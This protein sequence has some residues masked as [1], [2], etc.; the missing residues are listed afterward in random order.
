MTCYMLCG[1]NL[2]SLENFLSSIDKIFVCNSSIVLLGDFNLLDIRWSPD[3]LTSLE[4]HGTYSTAFTES[5][6]QH[7]L[8]QYVHSPTRCNNI[9]DLVFSDDPYSICNLDTCIPF[10]TSDH[11][12]V[13]FQLICGTKCLLP[14]LTTET[15]DTF[16]GK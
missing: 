4:C 16:L 1:M 11:N 6:I 7:G 14:A 9:L 10:S 13:T 3:Y 2:V 8:L 5:V 15:K 12:S